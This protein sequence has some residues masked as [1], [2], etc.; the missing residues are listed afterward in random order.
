MLSMPVVPMTIYPNMAAYYAPG[1]A[2]MTPSTVPITNQ[3]GLPVNITNGIVRTEPRGVHISGLPYG[4]S[5]TEIRELVLPYGRAQRVEMR[6]NHAIVRLGSVVEA[7][8]VIERLDRVTWKGGQILVKEDRDSA[9]VS[10][11]RNV[12][13]Y[14]G[15]KRANGHMK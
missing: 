15:P 1:S 4:V 11:P 7:R 9:S 2:L 8:Q 10:E 6:K 12:I 13:A 14:G 3:H 5:E